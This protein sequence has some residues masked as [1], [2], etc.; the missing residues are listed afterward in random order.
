MILDEFSKLREFLAFLGKTKVYYLGKRVFQGVSVSTCI[1]IF[2]N[3]KKGVE[4]YYK[5]NNNFIESFAD[6]EWDGKI[7][8]FETSLTNKLK[9][10]KLYLER[11]LILEFPLGPQK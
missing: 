1:L 5:D 10:I 8:K 3:G 9:I 2:E 4:L 11:Y 6:N 7:L